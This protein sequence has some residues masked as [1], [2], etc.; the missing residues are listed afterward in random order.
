MADALSRKSQDRVNAL[1]ASRIPLLADLRFTGVKLGLE[2]KEEALVEAREEALLA[3]IQVRPILSDR[4]LE[5]QGNNKEVQELIFAISKGKKKDLRVR[6]TD[7]MLMQDK[8]MYVP[9]IV[10]LKKEILD[11]AHISAYAM[12]PGGTKMCHTFRPFYYWPGM[13][14]EIAEYVSRCANCQQV[15]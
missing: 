8:R 2:E 14:R 6:E 1:Y 5:A 7:G 11:E 9:N 3:T 4:I 12:H 13:K 15:N 10:E